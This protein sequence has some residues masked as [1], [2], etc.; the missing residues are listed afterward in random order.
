MDEGPEPQEWVERAAEEHHGGAEKL[1]KSEGSRSEMI[2]SAITAAGLAVSAAICSLFSGHAANLAILAQTKATDQWSYYQAKSTKAHVYEVGSEIVSALASSSEQ[3][4]PSRERFRA[5]SKRYDTEKED[6]KREA[7]S[8]EAESR[9]EFLKHQRYAVAV[10]MFQVGI[11][12]SSVSI[13]VR[14]RALYYLSLVIG[15][16]GVLSFVAGFLA[17]GP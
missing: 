3:S 9:T 6:S 14:F 11:V 16:V 4:R 5:E 2:A 12:L 17:N 13:L 8:L 15:A 7:E 1:H 10:A